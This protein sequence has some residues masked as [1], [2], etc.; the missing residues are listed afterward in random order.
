VGAAGEWVSIPDEDLTE[1]MADRD[2]YARRA[3]ERFRDEWNAEHPEDS[4]A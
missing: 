2:G 3:Q 4:H 1:A